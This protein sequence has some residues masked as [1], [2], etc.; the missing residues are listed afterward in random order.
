[1]KSSCDIL[2][3]GAGLAGLSAA[4]HLRDKKNVRIVE[5]SHRVG[6]LTATNH[7]D[8]F[9]FDHT[10]HLLHLRDETIKKWVVEE[11]FSGKIPSVNRDSRVWSWGVY[12]R[13]PFQANTFGLPRE[14]ADECIEEYLKVLEKPPRTIIE[15]AEDF[16]YHHFGRGFAKYFMIPYNQKIWGVHPREM[17]ASWGERFIPVPK[18]EE[19]LSGAKEDSTKKLGYNATFLYPAHGMGELSERMY[20]ALKKHIEV[21][22][23]KELTKI[24]FKNKKAYFTDGEEVTYQ[25]LIS[26]IPLKEL[27]GH[28]ADLP[29]GIAEKASLLR[30]QSLCYLDVALNIETPVSWQWCYVP[31]PEV[32]FY[33]VG[34]YSNLSKALVPK[35]K[36]SLYVELSSRDYSKE[37]IPSVIT[38]LKN[39]GLIKSEE[40]IKFIEPHFVKYAYVIY[41]K[42]YAKVVPEIHDFLKKHDIH[43]IGRW[44]AWNYSSMEDAILMGREIGKV[45]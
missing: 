7:K 9:Y 35:G 32:P 27:L 13:Y 8:G 6:G 29:E 20:S 43:S 22:F 1:M 5:R 18:K 34:V 44:G 42:Q 17:S 25:T 36:S 19:V 15:T 45:L 14:I 40:D 21:E 24:D 28:S 39:M 30:C 11:L 3:I 37:V 33:R 31:S 41:D 2:I 38:Q 23:D 10:G 26:T 12:T 16:I 4:W